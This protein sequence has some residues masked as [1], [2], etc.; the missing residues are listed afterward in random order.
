MDAAA[1]GLIG[2]LGGAGIG[3]LGA[4]KVAADQRVEAARIERRH[5]LAAY[6]GAL[7]PVVSELKE[8][9]PAKEPNLLTKAIDQTGGEQATW[10]RTRKGLVEMSPHMFGRMDRLASAMARVQLLAMQP[11]ITD[12]VEAA[13]DYVIE[14]GDERSRDLIERWP[15]VHDALLSA[16]RRLEAQKHRLW[17]I[18]RG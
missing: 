11:A 9:P 8:M 15:S 6:V 12:A 3:F 2:A 10:A 7:T 5:A 4:I 18:S 1:A 16:S 17:P 13:N 14:L